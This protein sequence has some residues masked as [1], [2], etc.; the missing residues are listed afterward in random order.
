MNHQKIAD[1]HRH[2][3]H[4]SSVVILLYI[5]VVFVVALMTRFTPVY[6]ATNCTID[7]NLVNTCRP[8]LGATV[9]NYPG[10]GLSE[11]DLK[12]Q[13]LDH[14]RRIGRQLDMVHS[15]ATPTKPPLS[16]TDR[17]FINRADTI[18]Y[19]TWKPSQN[20]S[21]AGGSDATVNA[22]IDKLADSLKSVAP[23]K[24]LLGIFHEPENDVSGGATG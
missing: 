8:W 24:V 3:V 7:A 20:W 13:V 14:E 12:A 2:F 9:G 1:A 16:T 22:N 17:Y 18:L 19:A 10:V 4:W 5:V 11:Y 6:T 21:A 15:Y 23:K